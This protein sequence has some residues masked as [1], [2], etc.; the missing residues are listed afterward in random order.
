MVHRPLFW[1]FL[2][3]LLAVCPSEGEC[4][5]PASDAPLLP[6]PTGEYGVGR[7]SY[8]LTDSSRDEFGAPENGARRKMMAY[9]WYPIDR[10]AVQQNVTAAYL[11]N[12]EEIAP[13]LSP[14]DLADIFSPAEYKGPPSLPKTNVVENAPIAAGKQKFPLL[15]F[16]HGWGNPTFLY[17]AELQDIVSHGYIVVAIDHPYD[18]AFTKFPDGQLI[19][20]AQDRFN[21]AVAKPKGMNNYAKERVEVMAQDNR[22]ALT[23]ILEYATTQS[24]HAVF[25]ER[26]NEQKIGAFGHSIGG[27]TAARTCQID[28]RVKACMDQ[29]SADNRGSSFI[30]SDLSQTETQPFFLFVVSSADIWSPKA[31]NPSDAELTKQKL[32]RAEFDAKMKQQQNNQTKQLAEIAGGSYRL[33]I[34]DLPGFIHRSFTDQTLLATKLDR[35]QSLH[36]FQVAQTYTLAFFNKYL[37]GDTKTLLDTGEKVDSLAKL[38]KFPRH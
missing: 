15:L 27:L 1:F 30:V 5:P 37:K 13:K 16:C 6:A 12:F 21:S 4:A 38:E 22:Y 32:T 36:N 2:C 29:D 34:F 8:G 19:F 14:G 9:V 26:I 20:F 35:D 11:P 24:A 7:V 31:L 23:E 17:T 10:K 18:T 33:M 3:F 25:Y 28:S